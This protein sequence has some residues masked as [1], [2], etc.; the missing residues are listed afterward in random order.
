MNMRT[1][2]QVMSIAFILFLSFTLYTAQQGTQHNKYV[3]LTY[4]QVYLWMHWENS[5]SCT[6][7]N[8]KRTILW[9]HW[10]RQLALYK[11]IVC[12][13]FC[14]LHCSYLS[15]NKELSAYRSTDIQRGTTAS[16]CDWEG[17]CQARSSGDCPFPK[18][19]SH[20]CP[21]LG[22][23]RMGWEALSWNVNL[24]FKDNMLLRSDKKEKL[25]WV[26]TDCLCSQVLKMHSQKYFLQPYQQQHSSAILMK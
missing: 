24:A 21:A 23:P 8:R 7:Q 19:L 16:I 11:K 20:P 25:S 2:L 22:C 1:H 4:Y 26:Q 5:M 12:G 3:H 13:S 18:L 9:T 6:I 17:N 14:L 10:C 15:W